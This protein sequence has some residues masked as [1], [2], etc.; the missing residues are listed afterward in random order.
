MENIMYGEVKMAKEG[1]Q[2][3]E[4]KEKEKID[5]KDIEN[6]RLSKK[7]TINNYLE[8]EKN[9]DKEKIAK[10]LKERF[11]ER[12]ISPIKNSKQKSGFAIMALSCLMI[13]ALESF[14]KG[15]ET[16]DKKSRKAFRSFF[17]YASDNNLKLGIFHKIADD[18]YRGVRCGLLHQAETTNGWRIMRKG[19][20][21]DES[22]K[23]INANK[24]LEGI[25]EYLDFYCQELKKSDWNDKI[26]KN[27]RNKM[28]AIIRNCKRGDK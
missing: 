26:W 19:V 23:T 18:F 17:E 15:W 20:L 8:F 5:I 3:I 27:L 16:T 13:E 22:S 1:P 10:F 7:I 2:T 25:E 14:R 12:Y 28:K 6:V 11:T 21:F 9:R 24:F 4:S